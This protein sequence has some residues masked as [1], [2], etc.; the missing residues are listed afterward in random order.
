VTQL[1]DALTAVNQSSVLDWAAQFPRLSVVE[2]AKQLS[3]RVAPISLQQA[4]VKEARERGSF[5]ALARALL[6]R[7]MLRD[8]PRGVGQGNPEDTQSALASM[9]SVWILIFDPDQRVAAEAVWAAVV[10]ELEAHPE[11]VP[12]DASEPRLLKLFAGHA[13]DRSKRASL[14]VRARE[15]IDAAIHG[16]RTPAG[17]LEALSQ[18]PPGHGFLYAASWVDTE[19]RN[20]GFALL[21]KNSGGLEVPLAI[22]GLTAM[23]RTDLAALVQE[24]LSFARVH[25]RHLLS[26]SL[27]NEPVL[28]EVAEPRTWNSLDKSYQGLSQN[29]FDALASL[30]ESMPQLFEPPYRE[31]KNRADGRKWKVRTSGAGIEI[32]IELADGTTVMRK[33]ACTTAAK[34]EA[35]VQTMINEQLADGFVDVA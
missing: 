13:M 11:W 18:L 30:I 33:R 31:L 16:Q 24:S 15:R 5:P 25:N 26:P 14:V 32:E 9:F 4:M 1:Q 20:G 12:Q 3:G 27:V 8:F 35:E 17:K 34:A 21:Y 10:A 29:L 19:V 7:L 6:V 23:R 22:T 28:P 2:L